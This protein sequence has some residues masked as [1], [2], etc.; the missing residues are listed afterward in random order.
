MI[1]QT[2]EE[3]FKKAIRLQMNDLAD[4]VA[5]GG[6]QSFEEYKHL[7]GQVAGL[8]F[9]ERIFLDLVA[10]FHEEDDQ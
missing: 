10:K 3:L 1:S 8:A 5:T 4:V 2:F 6:A 7:T 9:A